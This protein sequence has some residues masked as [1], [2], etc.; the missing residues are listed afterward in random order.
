MATTNKYYDRL[1]Q[2]KNEYPKLTFDN[3]GY[4]YIFEEKKKHKEQVDEIE[5]ILK[6]TIKGFVRFDNFKPRKEGTFDIRCQYNWGANDNSRCFVGVGYFNIE[7]F[8]DI[9]EDENNS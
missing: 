2:I 3:D 8:K 9:E 4:E 7:E 6:K 1:I 5:D